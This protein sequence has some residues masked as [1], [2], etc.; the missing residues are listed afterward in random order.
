MTPPIGTA[1]RQVVQRTTT[2]YCS[3]PACNPPSSSLVQSF[4]HLPT[5]TLSS[6][7]LP[8]RNSDT[9]MV[10]NAYCSPRRASGN[11]VGV[12]AKKHAASEWV[13]QGCHERE[14]GG[15]TDPGMGGSMRAR[16][17]TNSC[18][19]KRRNYSN[20]LTHTHLVEIATA[21]VIRGERR[22]AHWHGKRVLR[23]ARG[24]HVSSTYQYT[25]IMC[26]RQERL[27]LVGFLGQG[28]RLG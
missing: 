1:G 7:M 13:G 23:R 28:T 22:C 21:C 8:W 16:F 26:L 2:I 6:L 15:R 18:S 11:G 5:P 24:E 3:L 19:Q 14:R 4:T 12:Y 9:G 25:W 27:T 20:R 10:T 17:S